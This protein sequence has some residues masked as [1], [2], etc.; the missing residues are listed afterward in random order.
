[1][2]SYTVSWKYKF[3][4]CFRD[5]IWSYGEIVEVFLSSMEKKVLFS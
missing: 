2:L 4:L 3:V 1:M 5:V